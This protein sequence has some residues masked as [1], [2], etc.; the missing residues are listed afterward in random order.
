MGAGAEGGGDVATTARLNRTERAADWIA[1]VVECVVGAREW[2]SRYC[3]LLERV[4][5]RAAATAQMIGTKG[6]GLRGANVH[7]ITNTIAHGASLQQY[8]CKQSNTAPAA[9]RVHPH[10]LPVESERRA[11]HRDLYGLPTPTMCLSF[12]GKVMNTKQRKSAVVQIT[13]M[14]LSLFPQS[15][16]GGGVLEAMQV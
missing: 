3:A 13:R 12:S 2:L 14:G 7:Q 1:R 15:L 11:G 16:F 9:C 4:L 6:S 10:A 5:R 8:Q